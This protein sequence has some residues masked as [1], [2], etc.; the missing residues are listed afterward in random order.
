MF[1]GGYHEVTVWSATDGTLLRRLTNLPERVASVALAAKDTL[2]AVAGGS[3]GRSGEALLISAE[4]GE[5]RATLTRAGDMPQAL[6]INPAKDRAAVG[7]ADGTIQTFTLPEGRRVLS[8]LQHA[9]GIADLAFSPDGLHLA[10][11]SRDRSAR[12]F[13][14]G[15]GELEST[16]QDHGSTVLAVAFSADGSQVI[17]AGRDRKIHIWKVN[18]AKKIALIGGLETEITRLLVSDK[19]IISTGSDG[20][21][22]IHSTEDRKLIRKTAEASSSMLSI[23]R[24]GGSDRLFAGGFDGT[25]MIW[26]MSDE[27]DPRILSVTPGR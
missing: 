4:T 25:V 13:D 16:Y 21:I 27:H 9:D 17:S 2:L 24:P 5:I 3:P 6:A 7:F 23:V 10:A 12:V 11:A 22:R 20:F 26:D 18:E 8:F 15:T 14:A 1:I 19:E